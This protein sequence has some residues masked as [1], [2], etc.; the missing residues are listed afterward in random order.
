MPVFQ[1]RHV[2]FCG[3]FLLAIDS[4]CL[5]KFA[6][7]GQLHCT[8]IQSGD[9]PKYCLLLGLASI[10]GV[11]ISVPDKTFASQVGSGDP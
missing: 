4:S 7:A 5:S 8:M 1:A 9:A 11:L 2:G 10:F 3:L 6:A